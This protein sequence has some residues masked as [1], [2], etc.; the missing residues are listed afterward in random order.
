MKKEK[1]VLRTEILRNL[2]GH[3]MF[4]L[5]PEMHR[6]VGGI[7]L[8]DP[9]SGGIF[10][11]CVCPPREPEK[12]NPGPQQPAPPQEPLPQF[13]I[14]FPCLPSLSQFWACF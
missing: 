5:T 13:T 4:A 14:A 9:L 10:S 2:T 11:G 6:I 1:L 8:P 3:P 7:V 12:P